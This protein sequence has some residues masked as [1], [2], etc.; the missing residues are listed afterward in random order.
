MLLLRCSIIKIISYFD[1]VS[2][3]EFL[4]STLLQDAVLCN[5]QVLAESTQRL[6][7]EFK[8][9]NSETVWNVLEPSLPK[10]REAVA[11]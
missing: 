10:L 11:W 2:C 7:S 4:N 8:E 1:S 9:K 6:S 3:N 5:L